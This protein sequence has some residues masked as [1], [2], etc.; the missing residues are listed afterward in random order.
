[1]L[2]RISFFT[3]NPLQ[4]G[5]WFLKH[6]Y[7]L[8]NMYTLSILKPDVTKKNLTGSVNQMIESAGFQIVAQR[9]MK[10]SKEEAGKF[11]YVHKERSFF[12]ELCDF[13]SSGPI[14]VQVLKKADAVQAYRTLMGSTDPK[15]SEEGTLRKAFGESIECNAVHGS[16]SLENASWEIS[17]FFG[18]LEILD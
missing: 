18:A 2:N 1:V 12:N 6:K 15:A 10:L 14:V 13:I 16:D 9:R 5:L 3:Q 8:K 4:W 17:F 11:Y 7:F